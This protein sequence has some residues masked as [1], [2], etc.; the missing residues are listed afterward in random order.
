MW[1]RGCACG[2]AALVSFLP[3]ASGSVR[4]WDELVPTHLNLVSESRLYQQ[5]DASVFNLDQYTPVGQ[6]T[7]VERSDA[8]ILP[9]SCAPA[10]SAT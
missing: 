6:S 4:G 8:G 7:R 3:S 9:G 10:F 2:Q 5:P 1:V